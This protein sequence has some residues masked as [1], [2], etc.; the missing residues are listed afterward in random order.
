M[1][2]KVNS[3]GL[4]NHLDFQQRGLFRAHFAGTLLSWLCWH[5]NDVLVAMEPKVEW[6]SKITEPGVLCAL[7]NEA[8]LFTPIADIFLLYNKV[9]LVQGRYI[10]NN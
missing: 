2:V 9:S 1:G 8:L 10:N 4:R 6:H 7:L 5:L 3:H